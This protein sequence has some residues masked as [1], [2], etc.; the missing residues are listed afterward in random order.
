MSIF[1]EPIDDILV[2]QLNI[3]QNLMGKTNRNPLELSFLNSNSSWIKL[4]SSVNIGGKSEPAK[5]NIL[6]GGTLHNFQNEKNG[7][8][9]YWRRYGVGA[10]GAGSALKDDFDQNSSAYNLQ[11]TNNQLHE[12]GLRPMPGITSLK[13]DS[14]GAY[15]S[16]RKATVNF[17]CWDIKQL[18]ILE[19]LYMRPGYTV[20]LEFGRNSRINSTSD[21]LIDIKL[22]NNFFGERIPNLQQYLTGLYKDSLLQG[23]HYDAFFGYVVNYK[24]SYRND[25][26][27]DCM[28][29][30][31]STGEVAESLKTN[32]SYAGA[33]KYTILGN[34]STQDAQNAPFKGLILTTGK[35][36]PLEIANDDIIR[37]NNEYSENMLAGL[38]Y[39]LY[40]TF[41]Y[42]QYNKSYSNAS[43]VQA[44]IDVPNRAGTSTIRL[45]WGRI[46]YN[47][48]IDPPS[49]DKNRFLFS[50]DNYYIT[51]KSFC[52]IITE[53]NLPY[54]YNETLQ[55]PNGTLTAISTDSRIYTKKPTTDSNGKTIPPKPDPLL[56]LYNRLILSTNPD[57][58][59]IRNDDWIEIVKG[60]K[61]QIT[62]TPPP[63]SYNSEFT[64]Q[65]YS[66]EF[67]K[68]I[69]G[70]LN[71]LFY[72]SD[73]TSPT[74]EVNPSTSKE[75]ILED[76]YNLQDKV[77]SNI[78]DYRYIY[79]HRTFYE[80]L[81]ANY[82]VVRGGTLNGV[83][84]WNGLKITTS[85][86]QLPN[87]FRVTY[88]DS[89]T[90]FYDLISGR[91][92]GASFPISGI[93]YPTKHKQVLS[94]LRSYGKLDIELEAQLNQQAV[95]VDQ[96]QTAEET[97]D[98][99]TEDLTKLGDNL[100][101][102]RL[103]FTD[104]KAKDSVGTSNS[105]FGK[106]G[107]IYINLK[108]AYYLA[109]SPDILAADP[110]G[111]N[112]LSLG[113]FFDT[114]I[115]NVQTSL[116]N[117]NNFKIHIDPI[118][119]VARII[120]LN[121]INKD[122]PKN[123]FEFS[124]GN[125][126]TIVR[127]LKLESQ[128]FSNQIAMMAISAQAQPGKLAYDNTSL[129]S[130]NNNIIDRNIPGKDVY[131]PT[132][133][134]D[135]TKV[136]NYILNLGYLVSKYLGNLFGYKASDTTFEWGFGEG[137]DPGSPPP[138]ESREVL[139][140]NYDA[141]FVNSYSNSLRDIIAY[142]TQT[143]NYLADNANKALLPTQLS[144]TIDGLA[145]FVIGNLFRVDN[146]F[147]PKF[148]KN[149][150]KQ[151]G[152]TI[153]GLNH[154][155]VDGDWTTT[156][157]AYPVDLSSNVNVTSGVDD[158]SGI[159]WIDD[160]GQVQTASGNCGERTEDAREVFK[161][162]NV[163]WANKIN[164]DDRYLVAPK[165]YNDIDFI[166]KTIKDIPS[167][168]GLPIFITSLKRSYN[169]KSTHYSGNGIDIQV[170][171]IN[172]SKYNSKFTKPPT[173]YN[174]W[175]EFHDAKGKRI[176]EPG[177]H[178]YN[179]TDKKIIDDI[180]ST[181]NRFKGRGGVTPSPSHDHWYE[182][183]ING[184]R[185]QFL[186]ENYAPSVR[187]SSENH[188]PHFHFGRLCARKTTGTTS[189]SSTSSS[190]QGSTPATTPATPPSP[191]K[192]AQSQVV[193]DQ[194]P[195]PPAPTPPSPSENQNPVPPAPTPPAPSQP[196]KPSVTPPVPSPTIIAV[197]PKKSTWKF[198][199]VINIRYLIKNNIADPNQI[200]NNIEQGKGD[201]VGNIPGVNINDL[202][203]AVTNVLR[204]M[205]Q[206]GVKPK[207]TS[208]GFGEDYLKSFSDSNGVV[209]NVYID[210]KITINESDD[211]LAWT[212]FKS[213]R[214]ANSNPIAIDDYYFFENDI[215]FKT[216][217]GVNLVGRTL[218][219]IKSE[220]GIYPKKMPIGVGDLRYNDDGLQKPKIY[221]RHIFYHYPDKNP[222]GIKPE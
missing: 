36:R 12:L 44:I 76:M 128:V 139:L 70:W 198:P 35:K 66:E 184:E 33:V 213:K 80:A 79:D 16:V 73:P 38:I 91:F 120:D 178:P 162:H 119:G 193:E 63:T 81:Q 222:E 126:Q 6:L 83:R 152:Y 141:A 217:T 183:E 211:G 154:D 98:N 202:D 13:I 59:W 144:L 32:Y 86:L 71:D 34:S 87:V 18:E 99:I 67:Q 180:E 130:Y 51:L 43:T 176:N 92:P 196:P 110:S 173:I 142:R 165:F 75:K 22:K 134:N 4:Q 171:G 175:E 204:K 153:T 48:T 58:C 166:I 201:Y 123:I 207:V 28:T 127:D 129:T 78:A 131:Y 104:F 133:I 25:G 45:D 95:A 168:K 205:Y 10:V 8:E 215:A 212:G 108:H 107:D 21:K 3:R 46:R 140:N 186:N 177:G 148:Y 85:K 64:K 24:W 136:I 15:G 1:N 39:E 61:V 124:I 40:T 199:Y 84:N 82:Q 138:I 125:N 113:K 72:N 200:L 62:P 31:I 121:Y 23:G 111:K 181:F 88:G 169:P 19:A 2:K 47:S 187:D 206:D 11:T 57:V 156:I 37:F 54:A 105:S 96:T 55:T 30:I 220:Y 194:N 221:Y 219:E 77:L 172:G 115:Q 17:Q 191:S 114:L 143:T 195:A 116:G 52:E 167:C 160:E 155:I 209:T 157:Q 5:Q 56:C 29:E 179:T 188:G 118:D 190:G 97:Q 101:N 27:Y 192:P 189:S 145:G 218:K 20:L 41:R 89:D 146:T 151:L 103:Y 208:V 7:K 210:W 109:K 50:D 106:I 74:F 93:F 147:I 14:I 150:A 164:S 60:S 182:I 170:N 158:F 26:G 137:G 117:V 49:T 65:N 185:Y 149:S 90:L 112:T 68:K 94:Y 197:P 203:T 216:G 161:K 42:E 163:T 214:K 69:N 102:L 100:L 53:Y 135:S 122:I 174:N 159:M 9:G 132:V